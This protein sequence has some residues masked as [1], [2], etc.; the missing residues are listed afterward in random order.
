[1][2]LGNRWQEHAHFDYKILKKRRARVFGP[3]G[4]QAWSK[5]PAANIVGGKEEEE[6][7]KLWKRRQLEA[8]KGFERKLAAEE[9][10]ERSTAKK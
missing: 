9:K 2:G 6:W 4:V 5:A 1:M 7:V 8:A 10:V 3:K